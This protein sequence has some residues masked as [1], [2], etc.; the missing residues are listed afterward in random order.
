MTLKFHCHVKLMLVPF[1]FQKASPV[2]YHSKVLPSVSYFNWCFYE[3]TT[4]SS[5]L[6][7]N[8]S[9]ENELPQQQRNFFS[10]IFSSKVV[11]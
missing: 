1:I 6:Y 8:S 4:H 7:L 9:H 10:W 11:C 5:F 2:S 3:C